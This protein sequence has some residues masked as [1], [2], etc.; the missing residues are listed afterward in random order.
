[1]SRNSPHFVEREGSATFGYPE[2]DESNRTHLLSIHFNTA[3]PLLLGLPD[4]LCHLGLCTETIPV[5]AH[6]H[7]SLLLIDLIS[8]MIFS[9]SKSTYRE[10]H[11]A[12]CSLL[13]EMQLGKKS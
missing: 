13:L 10:Y 12:V 9:E 1:M 8:G 4:G 6:T 5:L 2:P 11:Y 3:L 7:K